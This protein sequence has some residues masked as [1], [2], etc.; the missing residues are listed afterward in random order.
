M[1]QN[2]IFK[3]ASTI[4]IIAGLLGLL[5]SLGMLA[6]IAIVICILLGWLPAPW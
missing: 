2:S 5:I 6:I 1:R 3:A 4:T